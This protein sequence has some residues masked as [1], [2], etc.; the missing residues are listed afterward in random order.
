MTIEFK[1]E[2]KCSKLLKMW[3]SVSL[4]QLYSCLVLIK[5]SVNEDVLSVRTFI[6]FQIKKCE[7]KLCVNLLEIHFISPSF[8][9]LQLKRT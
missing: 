1:H 9:I 6:L 8:I 7:C 2:D 4:K 3:D 5:F